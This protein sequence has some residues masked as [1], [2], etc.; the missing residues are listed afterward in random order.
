MRICNIKSDVVIGVKVFL[1]NIK[2]NESVKRKM[3]SHGKHMNPSEKI[4][5]STFIHSQP[6]VGNRNKGGRKCCF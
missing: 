1:I 2:Y 6:R 4:V 5:Q 3:L